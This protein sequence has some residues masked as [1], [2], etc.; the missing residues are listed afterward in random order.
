MITEK[1]ARLLMR[2]SSGILYTS[3][4]VSKRTDFDALVLLGYIDCENFGHFTPTIF[5]TEKGYAAL[6]EYQN[7]KEGA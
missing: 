1:Q 6:E 3:S 5:L 4:S 2:V 7:M